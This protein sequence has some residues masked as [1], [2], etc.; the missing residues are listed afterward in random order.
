[1][2][3]I[4][5]FQIGLWNAWIFTLY[6]LLHPLVMMLIDKA[7]GTGDMSKK[8]E[9]PAL[10]KA[11]QVGFILANVVLF[12]GLFIYSI[13][14]PLK[15][16]TAWFYTGLVLCLLG[17]VVWTTAIVNIADIPLDK[18]FTKGLYRYSRHPMDLASFLILLGAG[19]ASASWLFL[20]LSV[21]LI[22]LSLILIKI[23]ERHCLEKFGDAYRD[24]VNR[25]PKW[26][27]MPKS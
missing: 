6:S 5:A 12:I 21:V 22:F 14:L 3:L 26:I 13:F 7:V 9:Y 19:I 1:M 8:M 4:P 18:P 2:S 10:S 24:Y 27:G 15:L 11:E 20:L 17:V 16:G 25:T 23:E